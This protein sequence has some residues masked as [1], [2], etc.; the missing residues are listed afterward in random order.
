MVEVV[1]VV[2]VEV[3]V[4]VVVVEVLV[5][6]VE[7]S[8]VWGRV[9]TRMRDMGPRTMGIGYVLSMMERCRDGQGG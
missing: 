7:V 9:W 8:N 1:V 4:A 3:V 6:V 2:R 5:D